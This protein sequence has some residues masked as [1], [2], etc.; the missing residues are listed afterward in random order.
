MDILKLPKRGVFA[1]LSSPSETVCAEKDKFYRINGIFNNYP[2]GDFCVS[3]GY[4][5][6]LSEKLRFWI[7]SWHVSGA[8]DRPNRNVSVAIAKKSIPLPESVISSEFGKKESTMSGTVVFDLTIHDT[9]DLMV[10]CDVDNSKIAFNH[11]VTT[12]KPFF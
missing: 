11:F 1:Y 9:V 6:C 2:I 10:S 4:L 8:S 3:D 7:V 5:T 12:I